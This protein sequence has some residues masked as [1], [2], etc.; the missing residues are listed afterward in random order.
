[1][2]FIGITCIEWKWLESEFYRCVSDWLNWIWLR[3]IEFCWIRLDKLNWNWLGWIEPLWI[4]FHSIQLKSSELELGWNWIEVISDE[5]TWIDCV[6]LTW[7]EWE[8]IGSP[9]IELSWIGLK[10]L[11]WIGWDTIKFVWIW[12]ASIEIYWISANLT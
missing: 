5:V 4:E 8:V 3:W 2:N 6:G 9:W 11:R 10:G 12:S 1:M 7:L